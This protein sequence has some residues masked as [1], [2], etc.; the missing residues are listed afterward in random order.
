MKYSFSILG[1]YFHYQN[2]LFSYINK[3]ENSPFKKANSKSP[4]R[5]NS[6]LL[7]PENINSQGDFSPLLGKILKNANKSPCDFMTSSIGTFT[8]PVAYGD[9]SGFRKLNVAQNKLNKK[10]GF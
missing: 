8:N 7:A 5:K 1:Y 3:G 6:G 4:S 10:L 2:I 9:E